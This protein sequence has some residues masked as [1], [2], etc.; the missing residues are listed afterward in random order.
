M[1]LDPPLEPSQSLLEAAADYFGLP[2]DEIGDRQID[3]YHEA[4]AYED[5]ERR[6]EL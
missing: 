4:C 3:E 1:F 5:C 2:L 6:A